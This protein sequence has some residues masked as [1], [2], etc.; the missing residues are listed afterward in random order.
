M[1]C[2]CQSSVCNTVTLSDFCCDKLLKSEFMA[3]EKPEKLREFFSLTLWPS[4]HS[5]QEF[6]LNKIPIVSWHVDGEPSDDR[7]R[8]STEDQGP[9][10][11]RRRTADTDDTVLESQEQSS[12]A[13]QDQG[14]PWHIGIPWD[15]IQ[16]FFISFWVLSETRHVVIF[17][18]I[19]RRD[20]LTKSLENWPWTHVGSNKEEE[21]N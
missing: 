13:S 6:G 19:G 14:T 7:R 11:S 5:I 8:Q 16:W 9:A 20:W 12:A 15:M 10:E 17:E 4:W 1:D 3:L 21:E 18:S 2:D